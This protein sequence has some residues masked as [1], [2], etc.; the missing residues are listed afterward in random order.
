MTCIGT[1]WELLWTKHESAVL[2]DNVGYTCENPTIIVWS[3]NKLSPK[4][5]MIMPI[6]AL[7]NCWAVSVVSYG[8]VD[9]GSW[10]LLS[11]YCQVSL[12]LEA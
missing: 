8:E 9:G 11:R 2:V 4:E 1:H 5:K 3:L 6:N 12:S 7:L 10:N